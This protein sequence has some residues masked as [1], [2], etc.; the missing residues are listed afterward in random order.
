MKSESLANLFVGFIA[1]NSRGIIDKPNEC[2]SKNM[3]PDS[4]EK[5]SALANI[6]LGECLCINTINSCDDA[7][8]FLKKS[9]GCGICGEMLEIEKEFVEHCSSHRFSPPD[10]LFTGLC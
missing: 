1:I 3:H 2:L 5:T 6:S 9:Y 4:N 8:P 7:K 10:D